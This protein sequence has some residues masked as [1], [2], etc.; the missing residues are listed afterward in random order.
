MTDSHLAAM[1][2]AVRYVA[3]SGFYVLDTPTK[4]VAYASHAEAPLWKVA[5]RLERAGMIA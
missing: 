1:G 5:R 2:Y 4:R 3:P